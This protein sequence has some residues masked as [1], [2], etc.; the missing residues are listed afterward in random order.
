MLQQIWLLV[1]VLL[2]CIHGDVELWTTEINVNI[3]YTIV[4]KL[5]R[6]SRNVVYLY[7]FKIYETQQDNV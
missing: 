5:F 6:A 4:S 7:I 2:L 1:I 3:C